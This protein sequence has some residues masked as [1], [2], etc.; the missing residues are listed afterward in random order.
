MRS[1]NPPCG[2]LVLIVGPSGAGKDTLMERALADYACTQHIILTRRIITRPADAGGEDH[3]SMS[4]SDFDTALKTGDFLIHWH[5]HGLRYALRADIRDDLARGRT[6]L[7]NVS[8]KV[9]GTIAELRLPIAVIEVTASREIRAQRLSTRGRETTSD[10]LGRLQALDWQAPNGIDHYRVDNG[11]DLNTGIER[12]LIALARACGGDTPIHHLPIDTGPRLIGFLSLRH[13]L[14]DA[15]QALPAPRV[16][17]DILGRPLVLEVQWVDDDRWLAPNAIG[18]ARATLSRLGL[19]AGMPLQLQP[20]PPP[21]GAPALRRKLRGHSLN[22]DEFSSVV[23]DIADNRFDEASTGAFLASLANH[24]NDNEVI[25]LT[26][27]RA[28]IAQ[29]L[30]WDRPMVV[31]KHSMGGLPGSRITLIVIPI[32]AAHGLIIPKASSRA[33]TSPAGT[34]DTMALFADVELGPDDVRRVVNGANGCIVWNGRLSHTPFDD[35]TNAIVRPLDLDSARMSV[36]SILSKKLAAGVTHLVVDLP[37]GPQAKLQNQGKAQELKQLMESVGA[38]LGMRVLAR[39]TDGT[40]PVGRGI[41]PNL[42]ARDILKV[43]GNEPD[44]PR[45]LRDKALDFAGALLDWAPDV[46]PGKGRVRAEALL[47]GGA[48]KAQFERIVDLQGRRALPAAPGP[49]HADITA[50]TSG[51]IDHIDIWRLNSIARLTG[52]PGDTLAG[53]DLI[54]NKGKRVEV[55]QPLYRLYT[56]SQSTLDRVVA[57]ALTGNAFELQQ[58]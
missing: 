7:A 22:E 20:A 8:R 54:A 33:I 37:T 18:L 21:V 14:H 11:V 24:L 13:P 10:I 31:D 52:A 28:R 26:R 46:A 56:S 51:R 41:G 17:V 27:A 34:A 43:L 15:I 12:F 16:E 36:A 47:S 6:V 4:E 5:A 23:H 35:M 32:V 58:E 44:A 39:I 30:H 42:E 45:D 40:Q 57:F 29:T 1:D 2:L 48:A 19:I 55:G 49:F 38:A 53:L 50:P 9:V 3:Q 25:E